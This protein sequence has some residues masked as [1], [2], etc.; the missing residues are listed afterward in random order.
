MPFSPGDQRQNLQLP[1]TEALASA[2]PVQSYGAARPRW[3][4]TYDRLSGVY[5]LERGHQHSRRQR[6]GEIAVRSL[7]LGAADEVRVKVPRVHH[8]SAGTR[9]S[10]QNGDLFVIR[11]RLGERVVQDDVDRVV[12]WRIRVEL[13]DDDAVAVLIE[14]VGHTHEHHVVVVH[15]RYGDWAFRAGSH[16]RQSTSL[17]V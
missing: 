3:N 17:G 6:L 12:D 10:D 15:Q 11:F 4:I 1:I 14:H 2:G 16:A 13:S 5:R 8:Y 9:I 7:L